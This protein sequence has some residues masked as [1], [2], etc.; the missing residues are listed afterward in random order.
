[1]SGFIS[2]GLVND[3]PP[4]YRLIELWAFSGV[5]SW[6]ICSPTP[7]ICVRLSIVKKS[8]AAFA[9]SSSSVPP[10]TFVD[11]GLVFF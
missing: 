11:S 7:A 8:N 10:A 3:P 6:V 5:P 9:G 1:M 4:R 2:V